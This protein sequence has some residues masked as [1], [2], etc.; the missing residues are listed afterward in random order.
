MP[1]EDTAIESW[2]LRSSVRHVSVLFTTHHPAGFPLKRERSSTA[3]PDALH[4]NPCTNF[5]RRQRVRQVGVTIAGLLCSF[6]MQRA[7]TRT[8]PPAISCLASP[9]H[10]CCLIVSDRSLQST[11]PQW[12]KYFWLRG[13][14]TALAHTSGARKEQKLLYN[15][16]RWSHHCRLRLPDIFY[17]RLRHRSSGC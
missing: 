6:S 1:Q 3:S 14:R 2:T 16:T 13:A 17:E 15:W 5:T 4:T 10:N 7:T 11:S 9:L 12:S 8:M